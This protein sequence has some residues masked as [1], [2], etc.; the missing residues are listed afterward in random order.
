MAKHQWLTPRQKGIVR[1]YYDNKDDVALQT[2]AEAI[3]EL[4]LCTDQKQADKLWR[5]VQTA[6]A[7][8]GVPKPKVESVTA[9]RDVKALAKLVEKIF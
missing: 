6:L 5:K 4:Y 9:A 1:R 7:N 8:A 3:S 2:L